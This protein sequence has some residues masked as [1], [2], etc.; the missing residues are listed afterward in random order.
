MF[1]NGFANSNHALLYTAR[2]SAYAGPSHEIHNECVT[3]GKIY[4]L[5]AQMK[6]L[7]SDGNPYWCD[8]SKPWD[9]EV[10]CPLL[11]VQYTNMV[12]GQNLPVLS[13][14]I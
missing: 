13:F 4:L 10:A 14:F 8:K 11:T 1:Q 5:E 9:L 12:C 7:D 6:L 2:N 3:E